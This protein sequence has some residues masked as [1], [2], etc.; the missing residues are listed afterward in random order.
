MSRGISTLFALAAVCASFAVAPAAFAGEVPAVVKNAA[1]P[2][3]VTTVGDYVDVRY[4]ASDASTIGT[5]WVDPNPSVSCSITKPV[6]LNVACTYVAFTDAVLSSV[7]KTGFTASASYPSVTISGT[8]V[9]HPGGTIG[10]VWVNG[11]STPVDTPPFC[12]GS[13]SFCGT[14]AFIVGMIS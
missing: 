9:S 3:R 6:N 1:D 4:C 11:V 14:A 8:N 2:C 10:W 12:S 13:P 5:A 7:G